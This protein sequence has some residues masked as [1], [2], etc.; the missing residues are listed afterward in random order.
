MDEEQAVNVPLR[1]R[2]HELQQL[3]D[4]TFREAVILEGIGLEDEGQTIHQIRE[5]YITDVEVTYPE[6]P[7][8]AAYVSMPSDAWWAVVSDLDRLDTLRAEWL[9]K[10]LVSRLRKRIE[11][12]MN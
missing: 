11:G 3:K 5:Q 12:V 6:G 9:Q 1:V 8:F 2:T 10:K 4:M 7:E